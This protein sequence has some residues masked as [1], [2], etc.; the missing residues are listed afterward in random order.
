MSM[1]LCVTS[2]HMDINSFDWSKFPFGTWSQQACVEDN[3]EKGLLGWMEMGT[4][5]SP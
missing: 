3:E 4:W 1:Y 5:A 2:A